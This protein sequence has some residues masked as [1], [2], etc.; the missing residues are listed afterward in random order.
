VPFLTT[1]TLAQYEA[2][3]FQ[4]SNPSSVLCMYSRLQWSRI[5]LVRVAARSLKENKI[6]PSR[7]IKQRGKCGGR[8]PHDVRYRPGPGPALR[9]GLVSTTASLSIARAAKTNPGSLRSS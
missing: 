8:G 1:H 2:L 3:V 5:T 7:H 4:N 9:P 6:L